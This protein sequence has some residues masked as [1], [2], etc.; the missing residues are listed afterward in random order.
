MANGIV[1]IVL[2]AAGGSQVS[3][4]LAKVG[5]SS[6]DLMG[7]IKKLG[8]AFGQVGSAI[9]EFATSVL[10][11]GV[12]GIVSA[13]I[14]GIVKLVGMWQKAEEEAAKEAKRKTEEMIA[15]NAKLVTSIKEA[16]AAQIAAENASIK[17]RDEELAK[18]KE[19]IR[20]EIE[21]R[22]QRAIA[23]G[24]NRSE[25]EEWEREKLSRMAKYESD[26]AMENRL[27][28]AEEKL[29]RRRA[30]S[31]LAGHAWEEAEAMNQKLEGEYQAAEDAAVKSAIIKA[32]TMMAMAMGSSFRGL[33]DSDRAK[34][35]AAAREA[36]A[37]SEE[38]RNLRKA[39]SDHA[40][41][42]LKEAKKAMDDAAERVAAAEHDWSLAQSEG[43]RYIIEQDELNKL[44]K[45]SADQQ[46]AVE[47]RKKAEL[48]AADA[49]H[50]QRMKDLEDENRKAIAN[51]RAQIS[52]QSKAAAGA[53]ARASAV[54][55]EF[56]RAFAMYRDSARAEAEIG[57]EQAYRNDLERLHKDARRYGGKWRIDELSSLMAAGNTQGVSDTL[58]GWRK[59]RGFTPQVEAMVRA[60]AAENAKTTVED[61]LRKIETN[62]KDL[63]SKLEELLS[64]KGGS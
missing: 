64:M 51:T 47:D 14:L 11:G 15:A 16:S 52:E 19:M 44:K 38:G 45:Q 23:A 10:K 1:N 28:D 46:K 8:S 9:G 63:S 27:N 53:N 24:G 21:L 13:G 61:E 12:F 57:E 37:N 54:Q 40:E 3:G 36:F 22:K 30:E 18:T 34:E 29:L 59:S 35:E 43:M 39:V 7:S 31:D 17:R 50:R 48:A 42:E 62:T 55:S 32:N 6:G 5:K 20:L 4:E 49:A 2:R 26:E 58:A 56:D 25:I 33:S 60:S 41:K